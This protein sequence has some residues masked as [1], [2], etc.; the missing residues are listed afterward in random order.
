MPQLINLSFQLRSNFLWCMA[1]AC[2]GKS[3]HE[4]EITVPL[5]IPQP[6][7]FTF[8]QA[9]RIPRIGLKSELSVCAA[10]PVPVAPLRLCQNLAVHCLCH[11][12]ITPCR[13]VHC[14]PL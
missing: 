7:A 9:D 12:H 5:I 10:A 3:T 6:A 13:F 14:D 8:D 1:Q 4:I 2:Y 11:D